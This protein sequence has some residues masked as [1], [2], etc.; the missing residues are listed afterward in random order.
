MIFYEGREINSGCVFLVKKREQLIYANGQ[1]THYLP[2]CF[3]S[4]KIVY[5]KNRQL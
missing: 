4:D 5:F 2:F 3:S 1:Y